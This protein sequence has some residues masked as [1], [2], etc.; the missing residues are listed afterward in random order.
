MYYDTDSHLEALAM[1]A[2]QDAFDHAYESYDCAKWY[3]VS[4]SPE[5]IAHSDEARFHAQVRDVA[6]DALSHIQTAFARA[7]A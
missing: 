5:G 4:D 7:R 6:M 3:G 1:Q 2:D